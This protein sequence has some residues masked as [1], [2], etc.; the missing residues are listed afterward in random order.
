MERRAGRRRREGE[1]AREGEGE[2]GRGRERERGNL[3][4]STPSA[5]REPARRGRVG[6]LEQEPAQGLL[7][8]RVAVQKVW[9]VSHQGRG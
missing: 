2:R 1:R 7:L 6:A 3:S 9:G 4:G 8:L 5:Q